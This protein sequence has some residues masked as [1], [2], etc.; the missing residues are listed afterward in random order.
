VTEEYTQ[1]DGSMRKRESE[2]IGTDEKIK[3]INLLSIKNTRNSTLQRL[4]R[5]ELALQNR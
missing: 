2:Y 5:D 1:D 3:A 4:G